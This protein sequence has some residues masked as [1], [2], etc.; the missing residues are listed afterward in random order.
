MASGGEGSMLCVPAGAARQLAWSIAGCEISS[1]L[2]D[3]VVNR[4][5]SRL[6]DAMGAANAE[7][8]R[9]EGLQ[10]GSLAS[11]GASGQ[12]RCALWL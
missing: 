1:K 9:A 12:V 10:L 6:A 4:A 11:G 2:L 3:M 7:L 8:D 5:S